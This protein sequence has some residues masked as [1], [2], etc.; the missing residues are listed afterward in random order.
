MTP[1][2]EKA[3]SGAAVRAHF[4][5]LSLKACPRS[6]DFKGRRSL[7][8]HGNWKGLDFWLAAARRN[9]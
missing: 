2:R 3:R 6:G 5:W 9:P 7:S 8:G 4:A 1:K